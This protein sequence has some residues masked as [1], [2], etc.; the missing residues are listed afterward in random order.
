MAEYG[1]PYMGSK[2]SICDELITVFP[3]AEHFYDLFGGGFSVTHAMLKRR[4][5]DYKHFHFNEIRPGVCDLIKR[6][7]AGEYNYDRYQPP[8]VSR[9][10]FAASSDP[11]VLSLWSFGNNWRCYLFGKNI[12]PIKKSLH[13]AIIFNRFDNTAKQILGM[14]GFKDGY[15]VRERRMFL[16]NRAKT[17][18]QKELQRLE[19]LE[20]LERLEQL[21]QLQQLEQ[22]EL[23]SLSYDQVT[24]EPNSVIYCDPPY[25]GTAD[26]GAEFD[27]LRFLDWCHSQAS[28]VFISEYDIMDSRFVLIKKM[29][30]V[31]KLSSK[32]RA[33]KIEKVYVNAAGAKLLRG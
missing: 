25:H 2:G 1:A 13:E 12:E 31:S 20:R 30:K 16:R 15:S 3:K 6:A 24:I 21:Q 23:T 28:P 8:W 22:L 11:M 33:V 7:I 29:E 17:R 14:I 9:E 5:K 26:Y 19:Q 18:D 32:S 4:S 27:H 10:E